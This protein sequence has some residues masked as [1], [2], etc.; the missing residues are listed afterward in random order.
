M[1]R[2][3]EKAP[4]EPRLPERL[5]ALC[6]STIT[7]ILKALKDRRSN[8]ATVLPSLIELYPGQVT[9]RRMISGSL[10]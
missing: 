4:Y 5:E 1:T 9:K 6:K 2:T 8:Q 3:N 10:Q 7:S